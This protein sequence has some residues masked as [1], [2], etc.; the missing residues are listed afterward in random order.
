[1]TKEPGTDGGNAPCWGFTPKA[2]PKRR[3][4]AV[5]MA[6]PD[7]TTSRSA[8][9]APTIPRLVSRIVDLIIATLALI[10][11]LPLMGLIILVIRATSSGPALFRQTRVGYMGLPFVMLKFRTMYASGDDRP[12]QEYVRRMLTNEDEAARGP[13]GLF[14]LERDPRVTP[15]GRWLRRRSLDELPQILNV[16]RG[17]MAIVGP[18]PALPWEVPLYQPHHLLRFQVKPG[19]TGLWQV[20]GRNRLSMNEALDLDVEYVNRWSLSLD[21]RIL[22]LTVPAVLRGEAR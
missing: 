1:L 15:V 8:A 13:S 2:V 16:L 10:V 5:A 12:H 3:A 7:R 21:L 22:A 17:N 14:K 20:S 18:R 11:L 19:I 4:S 6:A 9:R